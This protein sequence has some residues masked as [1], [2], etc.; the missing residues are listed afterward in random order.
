MALVR[1]LF[2]DLEEDCREATRKLAGEAWVFQTQTTVDYF[3]AEHY[4]DGELLRRLEFL[5]EQ[6]G[7]IRVEGED[8]DWE[9]LMFEE[10]EDDGLGDYDA[11]LALYEAGEI[12]VGKFYPY[13]ELYDLSH[14]LM[15]IFS[16]DDID[17]WWAGFEAL[18]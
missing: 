17:E 1:D 18:D 8:E 3:L 2:G 6:G 5:S 7:W 9:S 13:P 14:I 16:L 10:P 12:K 4:R 15:E 11:K